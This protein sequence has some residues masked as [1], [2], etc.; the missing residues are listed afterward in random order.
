MHGCQVREEESRETCAIERSEL[1]TKFDEKYPLP[2]Q[3]M[4]LGR[5]QDLSS[6]KAKEVGTKDF[7]FLLQ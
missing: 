5:Q 3:D 7:L 1:V 4:G 6:G 2:K